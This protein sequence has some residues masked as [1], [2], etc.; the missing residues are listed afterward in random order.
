[1]RAYQEN[2]T[3]F[4]QVSGFRHLKGEYKDAIFLRLFLHF[5]SPKIQHISHVIKNF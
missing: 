5:F 2:K 1:V 4:L 3:F